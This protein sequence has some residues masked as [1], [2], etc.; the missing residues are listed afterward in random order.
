MGKRLAISFVTVGE[1]YAGADK[2]NWGAA[3]R[4]RLEARIHSVVV[5]PYDVKICKAYAAISNLKTASGSQWNIGAN[6]RWIAACA[7][8]HGLPLITNNR[9]DYEGIPSLTL[10]TETPPPKKPTTP[11]L[12]PPGT[13]TRR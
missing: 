2:A 6:D 9:R 1:L 8:R 12:F 4:E 11:P 7:I 5:V 10:I 13:A 3:S